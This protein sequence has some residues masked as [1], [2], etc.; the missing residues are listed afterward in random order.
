MTTP[1][2]SPAVH[3][4]LARPEEY[5]LI[6][7]LV[8]D[9]YLKEGFAAGSYVETLRDAAKRAAEADLLVA[10]DHDEKILGTV[11]YAAGG[12]PWA[13][14]SELDEAGFRMLAVAPDARRR[15]VGETLVGACIERARGQ[16]KERL[17]MSTQSTMAAAH[18]LYERLGFVR[19]P[20]RDWSPMP[21]HDLRVYAMDLAPSDQ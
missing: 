7:D 16:G 4:R 13:D 6:G 10:V 15:G 1:E 14:V 18:R 3:V 5:P 19:A 8:A 9:T 21:G 11:T 20:E 2:R 17:V 12:T